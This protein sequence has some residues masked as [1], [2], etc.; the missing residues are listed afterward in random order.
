VWQLKVRNFRKLVRG[1]VSNV[2]AELN[3]HKQLMVAE[4][5]ALER[6]SEDRVLEVEENNRLR[7]LAR[8]LD[9]I[10]ALEEIKIRQRAR[11]RDI[12]E[13]DRNTAYFHAVANQRAM[14]KG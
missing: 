6:E 14:K 3:K 2:V 4:F 1:W 8:E 11:E 10:W 7:F 5:N 9:K 12:R 13:G